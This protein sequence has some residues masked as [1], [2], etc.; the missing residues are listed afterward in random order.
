MNEGRFEKPT[1]NTL[2]PSISTTINNAIV[3]KRKYIQRTE[4]FRLDRIWGSSSKDEEPVEIIRIDDTIK[5]QPRCRNS[6]TLAVFQEK[7]VPLLVLA[8]LTPL[9]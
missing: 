2:T 6:D 9:D 7:G 5:I 1:I 4:T 8:C 3:R